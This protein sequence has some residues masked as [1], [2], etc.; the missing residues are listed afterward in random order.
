V[1]GPVA[2]G[3]ASVGIEVASRRSPTVGELVSTMLTSSDNLVAELLVKEIGYRRS[4]RGTTADGLAAVTALLS[5]HCGIGGGTAADGSGL[6]ARN[7]QSAATIRRVLLAAADRPWFLR[8]QGGLPV[9]GQTG[10]LSSRLKDP[11]TAGT[12][13][14]KTGSTA[15]AQ[16]LSGYLTTGKGTHV[17]FA[18]LL[19]GVGRSAEPAIDRF[20][21]TL[22]RT[23]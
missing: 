14:A 8:F 3:G 9:A 2:H 17:V 11:A 6:S 16:V 19:N 12:V 10:T 4:G 20:V 22:A 13:R 1:V 23:L 5:G 18:V 7:R 21:T 15:T